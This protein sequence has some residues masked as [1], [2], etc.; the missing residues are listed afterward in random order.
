MVVS[1]EFHFLVT[2]PPENEPIS[3]HCIGGRV[4]S[5]T[6]VDAVAIEKSLSLLKNESQ[7]SIS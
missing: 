5:R 2:L 3:I 4:S 7:P 1:N 6:G